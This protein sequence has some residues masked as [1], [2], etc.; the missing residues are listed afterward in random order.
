M[1]HLL[2]NTEKDKSPAKFRVVITGGGTG[3]HIYPALAVAEELLKDSELED[4]LY[5]GKR[6]S[7]EEAVIPENNIAFEGISFSGM[8]R[9]LTWRLIPW[10]GALFQ[11]VMDASR[12]LSQFK[13][14]VVFGTG[15]YVSAPVLMA[16]KLKGIPYIIHE[17]DA[18]P[19]LVNRLMGRW[20]DTATGAFAEAQRILKAKNFKATGN[21][22]RGEIGHL[23]KGEAL[24]HLAKN[25]EFVRDWKES[26]PVFVITGGS[27]GA[28]TIN[29]AV[30]EALPQL[31]NELGFRVVHQSG[32]ALYNE[33]LE[34]VKE[35][36]FE[37]HPSLLLQPFFADMASVWGVGDL[38]L[39]RSGSLSLSELYISGLP[40]VLIPFPY[41]A[42]DHQRK[43]ALASQEAG[44]S[45]MILDSECNAESLVKT[46]KQMM[47]NPETFK[48]MK[49]ASL[50]LAHSKA[51]QEI[52]SLV[53]S[54]GLSQLE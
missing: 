29:K 8:P 35:A 17:P 21:P 27:Q 52:C 18:H 11:A 28:R 45:V 24:Q 44:A 50:A 10:G 36:G 23:S 54:T 53:K 2:L 34:A 3:G 6:E 32:K 38:A 13:P 4:L 1:S 47:K 40:S 33:T 9:S 43:N 39:C 37:K 26:D 31:V 16:A 20:A 14:H 5:V 51:T 41:A 30:V 15:G 19:G 25:S 12:L 7:L 22:I 48:Q 42:A 49:Q 46:V